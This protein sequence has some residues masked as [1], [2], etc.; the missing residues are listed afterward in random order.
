MAGKEA[1]HYQC[2]GCHRDRL[3][4]NQQA[5]PVSCVGCHDADYQMGIEVAEGRAPAETLNQPDVVLVKTGEEIQPAEANDRQPWYP[6]PFNHQ[7]H[8]KAS[9]TAAR[10]ATTPACNH[11]A[12]CHTNAGKKEGDNVKLA[13][14]MH[15]TCHPQ[16]SCIGCH[17]GKA[18]GARV[19]RLPYVCIGKTGQTAEDQSCKACHMAPLPT[20]VNPANAD[21]TAGCGGMDLLQARDV[22][23]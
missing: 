1:S 19:C 23:A 10:A 7:S 18:K 22:E 17:A 16:A 21:E 11:A 20:Y 5:G 12:S 3:A 9:A 6:V 13:Q 14:A 15:R 4:K 8:E 2:I